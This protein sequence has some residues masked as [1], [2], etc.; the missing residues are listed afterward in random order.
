LIYVT[1]PPS[2]SPSKISLQKESHPGSFL[3]LSKNEIVEGMVLKSFSLSK[4][5]LFI[6]GRRVM[7]RTAI[8]LTEGRVLSLKVQETMPVLTFKLL[9]VTPVDLDSLSSALIL[10][11]IKENLWKSTSE[12]I[13]HYG[14]SREALSR[15]KGL[16]DDLSLGLFSKSAPDLLRLLIDKSGMSWEAK[17]RKA[18]H[19]KTVGRDNLAKLLDGDL[20]G[21][22]S[23]FLGLKG[24]SAVLLK[25]LVSTL[26]QI[27]ILN[28]LGLEQEGKIFLPVPIQLPDGL[29]TVGQLLIQL[30]QKE[31]NEHRKKKAPKDLSRIVFLL[32]LSVL[33]PLR[34][35][36]TIQGEAIEG[37]FL[38]SKKEAEACIEKGIPILVSRLE[39]RGFSVL[40]MECHL[41]DPVIVKESLVQEIIPDEGYTLN[42]IA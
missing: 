42:L 37:R 25:R 38:L 11:A 27:Q 2:S 22:A 19:N 29:F 32:D 41:K 33:G 6:K 21:L 18:L 5:L 23:K 34:V 8:P 31:G 1:Y 9:G 10:S 40:S 13:D 16:M 7:A 24:E 12:N 26:T 39:E 36:L 20:K 3:T 35:D 14:L 30:P 28:Y 15:F 17:L 4:A